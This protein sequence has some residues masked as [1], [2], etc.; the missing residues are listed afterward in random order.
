MGLLGKPTILGNTLICTLSWSGG[1]LKESHCFEDVN[2]I[3]NPE[4]NTGYNGSHIWQAMRGGKI[5]EVPIHTITKYNIIFLHKLIDWYFVS[6]NFGDVTCLSW[7]AEFRTQCSKH[8]KMFVVS[9]ISPILVPEFQAL[10]PLVLPT[11]RKKPVETTMPN[12]KIMKHLTTIYPY[13]PSITHHPHLMQPG[14][15]LNPSNHPFFE[16]VISPSNHIIGPTQIDTSN[17][18][19]DPLNESPSA[20]ARPCMMR[21]VLRWEVQC[22]EVVSLQMPPCAMRTGPL[23]LANVWGKSNVNNEGLMIDGCFLL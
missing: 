11:P 1:I 22:L 12:Q 6:L 3:K 18:C 2:L 5:L 8:P 7:N 20:A 23:V 21:T 9:S 4:R 19:V 13:E 14:I 17:H 16:H 10:A 15:I